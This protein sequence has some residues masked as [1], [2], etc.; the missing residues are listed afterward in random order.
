MKNVAEQIEKLTSE[1]EHY[2]Q[3][4]IVPLN[5]PNHRFLTSGEQ[6]KLFSLFDVQK[7]FLENIRN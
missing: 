4:A 7:K 6:I 3:I 5:D 1:I 2:M